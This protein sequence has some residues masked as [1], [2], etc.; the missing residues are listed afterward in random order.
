MFQFYTIYPVL[1]KTFLTVK[2]QLI[3]TEIVNFSGRLRHVVVVVERGDP[4]VVDG[5]ALNSLG[6]AYYRR[7]YPAVQAIRTFLTDG[8][9][10]IINSVEIRVFDLHDPEQM[11]DR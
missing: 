9:L 11:A 5:E 2:S 1:R 10:G 3:G 7:F 8:T 4:D 6:M